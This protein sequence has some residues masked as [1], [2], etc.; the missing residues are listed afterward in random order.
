MSTLDCQLLSRRLDRLRQD[1]ESRLLSSGSAAL[2]AIDGNRRATVGAAFDRVRHDTQ[3][4]LAD[5]CNQLHGAVL[6]FVGQTATDLT[7]DDIDAAV[8]CATQNVKADSFVVRIDRFGEA[9]VRHL[10]RAGAAFDLS[11]LG[12]E[13]SRALLHAGTSNIIARFSSSL[14]DDLEAHS[15]KQ[16]ALASMNTK[17]ASL[18]AP[19]WM[20]RWGFWI[21]LLVA[22]ATLAQTYRAFVPA[23]TFPVLGETPDAELSKMPVLSE[24][25]SA[26]A[27]TPTLPSASTATL[28]PR[29]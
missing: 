7:A 6:S 20:T 22:A 11:T 23:P 2:Q 18:V 25:V 17:R 1:H 21:G 19:A 8:A 16:K 15:Q 14:R 12:L 13:H 9:V 3:T 28:L 26:P 10:G 24:S 29:P 27:S 4:A 5:Y